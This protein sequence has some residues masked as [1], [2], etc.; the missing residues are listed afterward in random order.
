MTD[1]KV[2]TDLDHEIDIYYFIDIYVK[3][4]LESFTMYEHTKNRV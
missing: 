2:E 1:F 3:G 4:H